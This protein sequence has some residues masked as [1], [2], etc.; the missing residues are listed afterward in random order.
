MGIYISTFLTF[1]I[2]KNNVLKRLKTKQNKQFL[3]TFL[4]SRILFVAKNVCIILL[5][6]K[7]SFVITKFSP[8]FIP[9]EVGIGGSNIFQLLLN[10]LVIYVLYSE[11]CLTNRT[12]RKLDTLV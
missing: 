3:N 12:G 6:D 5:G 7:K 1:F 8:R 4:Q 9:W 2:L 11:T 10:L